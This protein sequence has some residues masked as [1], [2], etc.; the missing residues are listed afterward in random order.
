[1]SLTKEEMFELVP[2]SYCDNKNRLESIVS[3][4]YHCN[5]DQLGPLKCSGRSAIPSFYRCNHI[6]EMPAVN[7]NKCCMQPICQSLTI[8]FKNIQDRENIQMAIHNLADTFA[9]IY[10]LLPTN[11]MSCSTAWASRIRQTNICYPIV[12][13]LGYS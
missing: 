2:H 9:K 12:F 11:S 1:M 4:L 10:I 7:E 3:E 6:W 5:I 13:C 8:V